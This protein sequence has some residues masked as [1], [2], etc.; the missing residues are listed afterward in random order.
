MHDG[1]RMTGTAAPRITLRVARGQPAQ[2]AALDAWARRVAPAA[3]AAI[4][5]GAFFELAPPPGVAVERLAAGCVCCIGLVPMRVTLTRLLRAHRPARILLLIAD[6][7]HIERV[8]ALV[9][10]GGFGVTLEVEE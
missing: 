6:A 7:S 9:T 4:T 10:G 2:Q 5:E 8:R 1:R 3:A